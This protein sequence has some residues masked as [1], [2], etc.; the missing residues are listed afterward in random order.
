MPAGKNV[1]LLGASPQPLR[2]G[3]G[4]TGT[5]VRLDSAPRNRLS[6]SLAAARTAM[7]GVAPAEPDRVFLNLEN[8]QG[9]NDATALEVYIGLPNGANPAQ[10][11]ELKAGSVGLFGLSSASDPNEAHGGQGLRL[12]LD[13]TKVIDELHLNNSLNGPELP[14]TVVPIGPS[15]QESPVTVGRVSIYRQG[16]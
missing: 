1:E 7:P 9:S 16:S 15:T 2:I 13:I 12:V 11:P 10:H 8:I 6:A 4:I 5:S 3:A 14:V